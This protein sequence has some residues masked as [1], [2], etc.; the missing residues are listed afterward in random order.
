MT[1]HA[2]RLRLFVLA[3]AIV[4]CATG[5]AAQ[6]PDAR[7][8]KDHPLFNRMPG[9]WISGCKYVQFDS[10][11]FLVAPGKRSSV[12]GQFWQVVYKP[13][14][15]LT[16]KPS[17]LQIIRNFESA[18]QQQ[19]G[20][21]MHS[22][23]GRCT[24][25]LVRDGNE[26]WVD[27]SADFTGGYRLEIIQKQAMAQDVVADAAALAKDIRANGH[28]AVYGI[29]FDTGKSTIKPESAQAIAEIARLLKDDPGIKVF[30][31][32]H[33]DNEGSVDGNIALSQARGEAVLQWLL[34]EHGIAAARL[35]AYGCGQ[36][37]PVASNDTPE[38]KARNR[39][40]ELVKQ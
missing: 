21:V 33:T 2:F 5:L 8:C 29:Y 36:F 13:G 25:K 26:T 31:V 39:R 15:D 11:A 34:R 35:R 37:A 14:R 38:G 30:V 16:S 19:G 17:E 27:L 1:R 4:F 24:L 10:H 3:V 23:K 32:G 9:Y 7:D 28:A 20:T 18:I 12:E 22:E 6:Q 40:V